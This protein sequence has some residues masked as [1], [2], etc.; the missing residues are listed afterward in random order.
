MSELVPEPVRRYRL[1]FSE[2]VRIELRNLAEVA[3]ERG[4]RAELRDALKEMNERLQVYPQ[5]GEPLRDMPIE[6]MQQWIGTV[7]PLVVQYMIDDEHRLVVVGV[8]IKPP[9]N[10]GLE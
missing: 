10:S 7:G 4:L 8:P 6:S 9:S 1:S 5:F 3:L 2:H